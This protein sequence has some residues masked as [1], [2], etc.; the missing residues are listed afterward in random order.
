MASLE[1]MLSQLPKGR[2]VLRGPMQGQG[3]EFYLASLK[4][5]I[6]PGHL[7][8]GNWI[9]K[10]IHVRGSTPVEAIENILATLKKMTE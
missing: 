2:W 6:V 4:L 8:G 10:Y 7:D 1:N 5:T 9:D 3:S